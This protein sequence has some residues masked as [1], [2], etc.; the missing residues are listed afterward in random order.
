MGVLHTFQSAWLSPLCGSPV[1]A[2]EAAPIAD[3]DKT[4]C[5]WSPL[6]GCFHPLS[7]EEKEVANA[8]GATLSKA[9]LH[10]ESEE[11]HGS[12]GASPFA[13]TV[14]SRS[15]THPMCALCRLPVSTMSP[16]FSL[17]T[18]QCAVCR[19]VSC[20]GVW[21]SWSSQPPQQESLKTRCISDAPIHPHVGILWTQF[22]QCRPILPTMHTLHA[23]HYLSSAVA[24]GDHQTAV[25][26][27]AP[28][29]GRYTA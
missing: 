26:P 13:S 17:P 11:V 15:D 12:D 23:L 29:A 8:T 3:P 19:F 1:K 25:V 7:E 18:A 9:V 2:Q 21:L 27:H 16:T 14:P 10:Q 6:D 28:S 4:Q 5:Y 24:L 20:R 22:K